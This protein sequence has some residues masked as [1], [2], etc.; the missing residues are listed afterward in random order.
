MEEGAGECIGPS[1]GPMTPGHSP[2]LRPFYK[3]KWSVKTNT[4]TKSHKYEFK[5][6]NYSTLKS[7]SK[8]HSKSFKVPLRNDESFHTKPNSWRWPLLFGGHNATGSF[9]DII[10]TLHK[11]ILSTGADTDIAASNNGAGRRK[12]GALNPDMDE[13]AAALAQSTREEL[14]TRDHLPDKGLCIC[15]FHRRCTQQCGKLL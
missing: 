4:N 9:K 3:K 1:Y 7:L 15:N 13:L 8:N 2:L 14:E 6:R 5:I 12:R 10:K 11:N